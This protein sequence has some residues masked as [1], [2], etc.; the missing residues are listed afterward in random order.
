M[1]DITQI[2]ISGGVI[3]GLAGFVMYLMKEHR[4]ERDE[5]NRAQNRLTEDTNKNIKENTSVLSELT[6]LLKNRK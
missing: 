4:S 1:M 2:G 5:W 3:A 6:T